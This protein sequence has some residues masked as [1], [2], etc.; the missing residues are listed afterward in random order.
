MRAEAVREG[1]R[2]EV[3]LRA[4]RAMYSSVPDDSGSVVG[5]TGAFDARRGECVVERE[6]KMAIRAT[7]ESLWSKDPGE[8]GLGASVDEAV[9]EW[10]RMEREERARKV[11]NVE[12]NGEAKTM[13]RES[14]VD[15]ELIPTSTGVSGIS[16]N[17]EPGQIQHRHHCLLDGHSFVKR[18]AEAVTKEKSGYKTK[19]KIEERSIKCRRCGARIAEEESLVCEMEFCGME[20]CKLCV[21]R[22]ETERRKRNTESWVGSPK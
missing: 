13:Q 9:E 2:V 21:K 22:W 4:D 8:E 1:K 15:Q 3:G 10:V 17:G 18:T 5:G 12:A 14:A 11:R 16:G 7:L 19:N 20:A 6:R